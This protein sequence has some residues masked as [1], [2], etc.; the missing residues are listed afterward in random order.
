MQKIRDITNQT[1]NN[2]TAIKFVGNDNNKHALWLFKCKCGNEVVKRG[3]NVTTGHIKSCGCLTRHCNFDKISEEQFIKIHKNHGEKIRN[4]KE[5]YKNNKSGATCVFYDER[6]KKYQCSV[7]VN[8]KKK[9]TSKKDFNDAV[10]WVRKAKE[11]LEHP[12]VTIKDLTLQDILDICENRINCEKCPIEEFC[13]EI[14]KYV[15]HI[16]I[17]NK[18]KNKEVRK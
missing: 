6:N 15:N 14:F 11:S 18:Y 7:C 13:L 10:E 2:L 9:T 17:I 8:G 12:I 3:T 1:F 16:T 4:R 5:L